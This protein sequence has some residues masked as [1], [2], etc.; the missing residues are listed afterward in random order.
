MSFTKGILGFVV[1]DALG[2]P[3]E[4]SARELLKKSPVKTMF[5]H[6]TH[7]QPTGTWSD[8]SSMT[9]C[10][11][12][13]LFKKD[14]NQ[15][16]KNFVKWFDESYWTPHGRVFDIGFTTIQSIN[17]IKEG[18][19]NTGGVGE[20]DNG[21]GSLMRVLPLA[22]FLYNSTTSEKVEIVE[23][24]S[25]ITHAH[26]ISKMACVFYVEFIIQL[27]KGKSKSDAYQNSITFFQEVYKTNLQP[28]SRILSGTIQNLKESEINSTGYVIYTLEASLWCFLNNRT[29][30]DIVLTAVNLG[31]DTD[32]TGAVAGS[33][34]GIYYDDIPEN[35]I[36][37]LSRLKDVQ[38]LCK[39]GEK[40]FKLN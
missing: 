20:R 32:T 19:E 36:K 23:M 5:G 30:K 22:Y 40:F 11:V 31:N 25:S 12:E 38:D 7:D 34:A 3:V 16:G 8:D 18:Y 21:N 24:V 13:A 37:Q 28:F 1:G 29:Y 9:F 33:M 39:R 10:T 35:W 15:I 14:F 2:V 4:F 6:G 27:L 26:H 17:R